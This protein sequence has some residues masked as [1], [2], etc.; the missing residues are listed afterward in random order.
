MKN[1]PNNEQYVKL[2]TESV[3]TNIPIYDNPVLRVAK[4]S[5]EQIMNGTIDKPIFEVHKDYDTD[6]AR[7][8]LE[9]DNTFADL[10]D[11]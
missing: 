2:S 3:M 10:Q 5:Q 11:L 4:A 8:N 6:L 1:K 7:D 9:N